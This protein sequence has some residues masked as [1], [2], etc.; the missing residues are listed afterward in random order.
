LDGHRRIQ[1]KRINKQQPPVLNLA[2]ACAL[3]LA[4]KSQKTHAVLSMRHCSHVCIRLGPQPAVFIQARISL[5][6]Q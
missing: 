6:I 4:S 2:C 3:F 1:V 5:I